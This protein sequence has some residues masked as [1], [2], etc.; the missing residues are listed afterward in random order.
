MYSDYRQK[1]LSVAN[2]QPGDVLEYQTIV[3][4]KPLAPN[5]FWYERS[6]PSMVAVLDER[7]EIDVPKSRELHLK[8]SPE[9]K[10]EVNDKGDR[11][12]YTWIR[13]DFVPD[14]KAEARR[15]L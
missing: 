9:H 1:H 6:F 8:C 13:K 14:R 3:N 12:V 7:L 5:Q 2:L 11:R 15:G 4:V 10:Y